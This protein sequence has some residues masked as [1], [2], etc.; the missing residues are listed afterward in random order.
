MKVSIRYFASLREALGPEE[1]VEVAAGATVSVLRD[2]LLLLS[3]PHAR[4]L[5]RDRAVRYALNQRICTEDE[6][7][8]EGAEVAFFPPVTGG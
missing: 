6:V 5:S 2:Q 3:E 8:A 1:Q 4:V 7:L